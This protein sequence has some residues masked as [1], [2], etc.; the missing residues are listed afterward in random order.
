MMRL[1]DYYEEPASE[2][3]IEDYRYYAVNLRLDADTF[4]ELALT[5]TDP[6][7]YCKD[8]IRYI[9]RIKNWYKK[10]PVIALIISGATIKTFRGKMPNTTPL[11]HI[12]QRSYG[13]FYW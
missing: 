7:L 8:D 2:E 9:D 5:K 12:L 4:R 6:Y 13:T 11:T 1:Q 3:Y 10:M